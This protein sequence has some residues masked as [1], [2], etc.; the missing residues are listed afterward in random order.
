MPSSLPR[1]SPH[2][3]ALPPIFVMPERQRPHPRCPDR[4]SIGLEDA[5]YN[6]AVRQHVEILVIPFAGRPGGRCAFEDQLVWH[7]RSL[8]TRGVP[9]K[10]TRRD[11]RSMRWTEAH[12]LSKSYAGLVTIPKLPRC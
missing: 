7:D 4:R 9:K 11:E 3:R 10:Q 1:G 6:R 12:N 2:S 5:S 8:R